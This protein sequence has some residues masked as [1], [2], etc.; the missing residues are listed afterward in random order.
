[1]VAMHFAQGSSHFSR[2]PFAWGRGLA[3]GAL[4][5]MALAALESLAELPPGSP[6]DEALLFMA[7]LVLIYTVY[8]VVL[9]WTAQAV[10]GRLRPGWTILL[11]LLEAILLSWSWR[12]N[13][14]S[15][16]VGEQLLGDPALQASFTYNLWL[17][18]VYGGAFV[19]FCL[20]GQR[21][22]RARDVLARAEIER[23][24]TAA[25]LNE[26]QFEAL[27]G[28][29]DPALLLRA[30]SAL[31][32]LYDS[33]RERAEALLDAFVAF[34]RHAM[35]GV[36]SGRSSILAE[37]AL[38]RAY[39]QL[40]LQL[41]PGRLL[42]RIVA[43]VPPRDVPFPAL[44]L[45]PLVEQLFAAQ[46]SPAVPVR[47]ELTTASTGMKLCLAGGSCSGEWLN[48]DMAGRLQRTLH[49]LYGDEGRWM[50]GG[51]PSLTLWLPLPPA[52][53]EEPYHE[54]R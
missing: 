35:P 34:L 51:S 22:A 16:R 50:A 42:C 48:R 15:S 1:M 36:R 27:K 21:M 4:W 5:G 14:T 18:L 29:V 17:L 45:L 11:F 3:Y 12:H 39:A 25:M 24:R 10:A 8:G 30:M 54:Q 52:D 41:E 38:L 6:L 53:D 26:A 28:R 7:G 46:G 40:L 32:E 20:I 49:A 37:L 19:W 33:Q 2:V 43:D 23:S 44:L 47:V 13:T 9:A 31:R